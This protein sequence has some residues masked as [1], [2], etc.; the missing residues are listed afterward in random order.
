M[1][2]TLGGNGVWADAETWR[3]HV[4]AFRVKP[5]DTVAAGDTWGFL[6]EI[7]GDCCPTPVPRGEGRGTPVS[8]WERLNEGPREDRWHPVRHQG[9]ARGCPIGEPATWRQT[10]PMPAARYSPARST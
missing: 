1:L 7:R 8:W 4:P 2:I 9:R 10:T 5:I 3:G 6:A